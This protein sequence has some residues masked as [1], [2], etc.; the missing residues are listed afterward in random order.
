MILLRGFLLL[1][2]MISLLEAK[3]YF[4]GDSLSDTGNLPSALA[5]PPPYFA[6][7]F[8]NG[9][10]WTEYF[11]TELGRLEDA[12]ARLSGGCNYAVGG[13]ETTETL[14]GQFALF[15]INL[16]FFGS[17]DEDDLCV[18]WIGA[19]DLLNGEGAEPEEMIE[20]VTDFIDG[21]KLRSADKF[22]FLNLPDLSKIPQELN[23]PNRVLLR[24]R[25]IDYNERLAD[26]VA[27][28]NEENGREA[29]LVDIFSVYEQLVETP[30]AF[31]FISSTQEAFDEDADILLPNANDYI[32]WD[33]LH[34]TTAAHRIIGQL[35]AHAYLK[36][37]SY[38]PI[39]SGKDGEDFVASWILP[40]DAASIQVETSN[41]LMTN[42]WSDLGTPQNVNGGAFVLSEEIGTGRN[43]FR[44][45]R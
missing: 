24:N 17:L 45:V 32:S 12:E 43:F 23:N 28:I 41:S 1:F 40:F 25:C 21:L 22:L 9:P 31:D 30:Q 2:F 27:S 36:R 6:G 42:S 37:S 38:L 29:V 5:T 4:F 13:S 18:L 19:N 11:A 14:S 15:Q 34:P 8:S 20:R 33:G 16:G 10:V 7:R 3:I 26:L 39:H 35:A 44:L